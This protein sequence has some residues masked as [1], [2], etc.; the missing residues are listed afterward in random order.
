MGQFFSKIEEK[1]DIRFDCGYTEW[2][3][4]RDN[5]LY[6]FAIDLA[7]PGRSLNKLK[8]TGGNTYI[9]E[10]V[11][12]KNIKKICIAIDFPVNNKHFYKVKINRGLTRE[13]L[14]YLISNYFKKMYKEEE[15]S[16]P[17]KLWN[18]DIKCNACYTYKVIETQVLKHKKIEKKIYEECPICLDNFNEKQ[19]MFVYPCNHY[20]HLECYDKF[21]RYNKNKCPLCNQNIF[22]E[23]THNCGNCDNGIKEKRVYKGRIIP[24]YLR[25]Y[26][27]GSNNRNPTEGIHEIGP[28]DLEN[29]LLKSVSVHK[30][31]KKMYLKLNII[32]SE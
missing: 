8:N 1:P 14:I 2:R 17:F 25:T 16:T 11:I 19:M 31:G 21:N 18:Y 27:L 13:Q 15:E 3:I 23:K 30:Y 5:R 24:N 26:I 4:R 12:P 9:K 28:Y 6:D 7:Y 20:F 29:L 10:L 32:T 22:V